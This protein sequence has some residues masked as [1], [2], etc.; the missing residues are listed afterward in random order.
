MRKILVRIFNIVFL[1]LA[2]FAII[3][4]FTKPFLSLD[5]QLTLPSEKVAEVIPSDVKDKVSE[6]DLKAALP[7]GVV[8]PLKIELPSKMI[9]N[10]KDKEAIETTVSETIDNTVNAT[11]DALQP[12]IHKLAEV[13]AKSTAKSVI[14]D[15]ISNQIVSVLGEGTDGKAKMAEAGIDDAY[16]QQFTDE[17]YAK[18]SQ[19]G[20]VKEL[21]DEVVSVKMNDIISKLGAANPESDFAKDPTTMA[22]DINANIESSLKDSLKSF[23]ICD[24]E[25]NIKPIDGAIDGLLCDLLDQMLGSGEESGGEESTKTEEEGNPV[26]EEKG[27]EPPTKLRI[28]RG[29][30]ETEEN[31]LKEKIRTLI[32]DKLSGLDIP[33][34]V[35][36]FGLYLFLALGVFAVPWAL[37]A[38]LTILRTIR[39]RKCWTKPWIVFTFSFITLILGVGLTL[40]TGKL[41]P[42]IQEKIPQI[43]EMME[44]LPQFSLSIK[45][46]AYMPSIVYLICIPVAIVY[47]IISH[48][49]KKEFKQYKREK[50]HA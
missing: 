16:L 35:A 30:T 7:D 15:Q 29:E 3:S 43:G 17:V 37:F 49:V 13:I 27:E 2:A 1:G 34:K 4:L 44:K 39:K 19:G 50:R 45:T 9:V 48:K 47:A 21:M 38:L 26:E 6:E 41:L 33:G 18:L 22:N 40:A 5:M 25:G 11:V 28:T 24:D 8:V 12:T 23:N 46:F 42:T 31:D 10:Y 14:S 20:T 32:N 36:D